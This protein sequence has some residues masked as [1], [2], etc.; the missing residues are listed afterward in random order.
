MC[1]KK[2]KFPCTSLLF[3]SKIL[4]YSIIHFTPT[5][6]AQKAIFESFDDYLNQKNN[7]NYKMHSKSE[8]SHNIRNHH[9]LRIK[10]D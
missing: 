7:T 3:I 5:D 6:D 1:T 8:P 4:Y 2:Q 10:K 9:N